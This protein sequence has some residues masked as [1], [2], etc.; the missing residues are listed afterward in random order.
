[1]TK[2]TTEPDAT[3]LNPKS[4][5]KDSLPSP[6][7]RL[8]TYLEYMFPIAVGMVYEALCRTFCPSY[9]EEVYCPKGLAPL[10][11]GFETIFTRY[12]FRPICDCWFRVIRGAPGRK[13]HLLERTSGD[14]NKTFC[15]SG[16]AMELLN[17]SSYNYLG[18]AEAKGPCSEAVLRTIEECKVGVGSSRSETGSTELQSRVEAH[19]AEFVGME[20]A[21]VFNMG[22]ATNALM[23][24]AIATKGDLIISDELNHA[25]L[26]FGSRLSGA[27]IIT[28]R[29]NDM[30]DLERLLRKVISHGQFRIRRPWRKIIVIVEG[31]YSME[32]TIVNLPQLL[33]LRAKYRFYLFLDEAHSIGALGSRGR[34]VCDHYGIHPS[35]VDLLMGTFTKSF[36]AAGGYIA[37]SE[38]LIKHFK[39]HSLGYVYAE[40]MPPA[41]CQQVLSSLR[42][43]MGLDGGDLGQRRIAQL[44]ANSLHFM[45][46]LKELGFMVYGDEGSPVIP[47]LIFQ[48]SKLKPF[49]LEAMK[50]GIAVVVVGFPATPIYM[51]RARFCISAAHTREDLD[52]ALHQLSDIGDKLHLKLRK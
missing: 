10:T 41:V 3:R 16:K 52:W 51:G 9:D 4:E 31:L 26:V 6:R 37:G 34:G 18:F 29:H 8:V 25:S 38:P 20:A 14:G 44:Y 32:A 35:Q 22:F 28:F 47:L 48:L 45:R 42:I 11:S 43:I 13:V 2:K 50:R 40:P 46:G 30:A 27:H 15:Y 12:V 17:L 36:G 39:Q 1:M 23:I 49:S 33:E 24:S 21:M 5:D 19:V 7:I